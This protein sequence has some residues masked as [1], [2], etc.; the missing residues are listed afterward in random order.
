MLPTPKIELS[1]VKIVACRA[2]KLRGIS[3]ANLFFLPI[4][5]SPFKNASKVGNLNGLFE[6]LMVEKLVSSLTTF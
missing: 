5:N 4:L 2:V 1:F 6:L 3:T